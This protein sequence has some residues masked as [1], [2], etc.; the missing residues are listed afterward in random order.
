MMHLN[1]SIRLRLWLGMVL[2]VL[3]ALGT[4]NVLQ[5]SGTLCVNDKTIHYKT[6]KSTVSEVLQEQ[7]IRLGAKDQVKPTGSTELEDG[8]KIIVIRAVPVTVIVDGKAIPVLTV[9]VSVQKVLALAGVKQGPKDLVSAALDQKITAGQQIRVTRVSEKVVKVQ[10]AIP[11]R[12]E[13]VNDGTLEKG[14][15]RTVKRGT[16]GLAQETIKIT[17]RDGKEYRRE[18]LK[19]EVLRKPGNQIVAAGTITEVSRGS[20]RLNFNHAVMMASTAYTYTG[21]NTATGKKPQV[22]LVAVDPRVVPLGSRLY[23]EGYGFA[24]ASDR[25]SSIKGNRLDVFLESLAQCRKWGR[26]TV[27][28]YVLN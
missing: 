15:T 4:Y 12:Q 24:R 1:R 27:K 19:A 25:G 3:I 9:P 14:L 8:L 7:G 18:V 26:R 21:R 6:F 2:A 28:V 20:L 10:A 23:I 17:Y 13:R 16:V 5:K 11:Y 22:G